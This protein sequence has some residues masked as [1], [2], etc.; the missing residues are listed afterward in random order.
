MRGI[1]RLIQQVEDLKR[2]LRPV[3]YFA[4]VEKV[5]GGWMVNCALW[6]GKKGTYRGESQFCPDLDSVDR[7]IEDMREKYP[8]RN[9]PVVIINDMPEGE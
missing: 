6:Q 7:H 9:E 1:D 2:A 5:A 3:F 8:G 4:A